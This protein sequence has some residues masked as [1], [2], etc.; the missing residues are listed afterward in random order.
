MTTDQLKAFLDAHGVSGAPT[1]AGW[2]VVELAPEWGGDIRVANARNGAVYC[3][4]WRIE[5]GTSRYVRHAPLPDP[6]ALQDKLAAADAHA[7]ALRHRV[8]ELEAEVEALR[9]RVA[10]VCDC[11]GSGRHC[12]ECD[13]YFAHEMGCPTGRQTHHIA[14]LHAA[15]SGRGAILVSP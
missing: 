14:T 12:E 1:E 7:E 4:G 15:C 2:Y 9:G 10:V 5:P 6:T 11:G 13:G 3:D 8:K